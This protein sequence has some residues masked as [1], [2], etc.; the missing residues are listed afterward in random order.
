MLTRLI[1]VSYAWLLEIALWLTLIVAGIVG[2]NVTVPMLNDA[3]AILENEF[4]WKLGGALLF[5]VVA[6]LIL[7]VVIGPLMILLDIRQA[8]RRIDGRLGQGGEA[9]MLLSFERKEP[10]L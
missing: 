3:G 2:Y 8:L 4:A 10:T 5:P 1:V 6:F 7:T 9:S